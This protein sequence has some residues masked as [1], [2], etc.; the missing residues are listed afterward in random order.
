[1]FRKGFPFEGHPRMAAQTGILLGFQSVPIVFGGKLVA[2]GAMECL[3]TAD[4]RTRFGMTSG[5][6]FGGWFDRVERW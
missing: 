2:I 1:M 3:H 4:I 5:A 6:F